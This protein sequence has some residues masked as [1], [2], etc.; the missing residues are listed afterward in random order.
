MLRLKDSPCEN[1]FVFGSCGG[2]SQ[3]TYGDL[4]I[5]DT[6]YN[7][8]SFSDMLNFKKQVKYYRSSADLLYFFHKKNI[9]E[10]LTLT[11][12][13]CVSSLY[14]E[15]KFL[16]WFSKRE[17]YA[18]DME[19]SIILSASNSIKRKAICLMYVSDIVAPNTAMF[20]QEEKSIKQKV[21]N[22]RKNL[23]EMILRF[24]NEQ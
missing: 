3:V 4:V 14:L 7:L 8:E 24:C 22:S 9:Y 21:S 17:I 10:Q 2:Y 23:T 16:D 12:S 20:L 5:I 6:A 18:I 15:P 19:S 11:N 13:A 1:I